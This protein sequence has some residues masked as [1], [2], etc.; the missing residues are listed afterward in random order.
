MFMV[1]FNLYSYDV[2]ILKDQFPKNLAV[3]V[4]Y[5]FS[6]ETSLSSCFFFKAVGL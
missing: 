2:H 5:A 6:L 4:H 1:Y 3:N